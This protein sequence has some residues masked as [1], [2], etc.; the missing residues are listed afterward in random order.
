MNK[1]LTLMTI[2]KT[3]LTILKTTLTTF[4]T[5]LL[6][7][8][9]TTLLAMTLL[10]LALPAC[11][12]GGDDNDEQMQPETLLSAYLAWPSAWQRVMPTAGSITIDINGAAGKTFTYNPT[13]SARPG[14]DSTFAFFVRPGTSGKLLVNFMG[15]GACWHSHNCLGDSSTLTYISELGALNMATL[16]IAQPQVAMGI[17]DNANAANP[18]KDDTVVFIPYCT[19]DIHWGQQNKSYADPVTGATHEIRHRGFENFLSVLAYL[20]QYYP[21]AQTQSVFVIGQS[22]GGYGAIYNFPYIKETYRGKKVYMLGDAANGAVTSSFV[23]GE[24]DNWGAVAGLPDWIAGIGGETFTTLSM[25]AFYK[26]VAGHYPDSRI[27]QY[28]AAYDGNQRF[29]YNVM[30]TIDS[31]KAYVPNKTMWGSSNG[32]DVPDSISCEWNSLMM[33]QRSVAIAASNYK[34]YI[35][36][37]DVHTITISKSFFTQSSNGTGLVDWMTKMLNDDASWDNVYCADCLA[38]VTGQSAPGTLTCTL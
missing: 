33:S 38:P 15:G 7:T 22:A 1:K 16:Q 11:Q 12:A 2:L 3:T 26:A 21:P 27:A 19:G 6:A 9:K 23:A 13:C 4:K 36:P 14:A 28:T 32:Y 17:L 5:T 8:F 24:I 35:A 18:F 29:F 10:T 37:G 30:K 34:A 31:G 25:G 20:K